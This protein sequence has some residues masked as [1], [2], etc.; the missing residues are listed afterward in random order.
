MKVL[1][2]FCGIGGLSLGFAAAGDVEII[3]YD[4]NPAAVDTYNY[5]LNKY[6]CRA[7]VQDLME[8]MPTG[9]DIIVGGSPCQPFSVSNTRNILERHKYFPTFARYFDI[10]LHNRPIV[11]LLENVPAV[12]YR[13]SLAVFMEQIKHVKEYYNV[14][15]KVLNAAD[16]GVPQLRKRL[17]VVGIDKDL[18]IQPTFPNPTHVGGVNGYQETLLGHT[19]GKHISLGEAIGDLKYEIPKQLREIKPKRVK[20]TSPK[21]F[22]FLYDNGDVVELPWTPAQ[23][24]HGV[25]ELDKP[26]KTIVSNISKWSR[27]G[28]IELPSPTVLSDGRL[29]PHGHRESLSLCYRRLT[30]RE[31]LRI[32]SFPDWFDFPGNV[33]KYRQ[34]LL[35]GEAVPPILAYRLATHIYKLIGIKIKKPSEEYFKL[36]YFKQSFYD[37]L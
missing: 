24:K 5:N 23:D 31:C 29:R 11:F 34:Y 26:A 36:P 33:K 9:C 30:V 8:F 28:M 20:Q 19:L 15:F 10:V 1:D 13:R 22:Y 3:G 37:F 2:L 18:G 27:L 32:Q 16:F 25:F 17:F 6:N 4:I 14:N 7:E 35:V 21:L 12:I